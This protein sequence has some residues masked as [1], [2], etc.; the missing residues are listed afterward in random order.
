MNWT[1]LKEGD[2]IYLIVPYTFGYQYDFQES[3]ITSID[4][5]DDFRRIYFGYVNPGTSESRHSSILILEYVD[6]DL[7]NY[8]DVLRCTQNLRDNDDYSSILISPDKESLI[9]CFNDEM[10]EKSE[11]IQYKIEALEEL[12]DK[13]KNEK[14]LTSYE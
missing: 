7:D 6:D 2:K 12:Q 1:N 3:S 13:I 4:T 8:P 10:K 5:F 9:D 14:L 11:D